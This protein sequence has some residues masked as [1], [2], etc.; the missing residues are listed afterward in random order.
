MA[1]NDANTPRPIVIDAGVRSKKAIKRLKKGK[2]KLIL[3]LQEA[4]DSIEAQLGD[5][6]K[7]KQVIPVV[8]VYRRKT[9]TPAPRLPFPFPFPFRLR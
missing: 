2:G 8:V 6:A 3:E 9:P 5:E 4:I 7:G 1:E